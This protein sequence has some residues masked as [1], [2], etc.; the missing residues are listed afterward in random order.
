MESHE[1]VPN[2]LRNQ[3]RVRST[4]LPVNDRFDGA[5][6]KLFIGKDSGFKDF[7]RRPAFNPSAT[8]QFA[9]PQFKT[10]QYVA[11][12]TPP[13]QE[14]EKKSGLFGALNSVFK[15]PNE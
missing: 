11:N 10:P 9:K 5:F 4:V 2:A 3:P 13:P 6:A 7:N 1:V 14:E 8:G 15:K 12:P